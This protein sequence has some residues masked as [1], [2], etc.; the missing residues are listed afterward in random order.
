[1]VVMQVEP[2]RGWVLYDGDCGFCSRWVKFWAHTLAKRGFQIAPLQESWVRET[3]Q[4]EEIEL[5]QDLRL[6]TA[7]GEMVSGADVY[8]YVAKRVWWAKPFYLLFS[9]KL[10]NPLIHI[11]YRWFARNRYCVSHACRL[12]N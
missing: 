6:V 1:M 9:S 12:R 4:M 7:G 10:F 3:L 8:L 5:L 2:N 11:G